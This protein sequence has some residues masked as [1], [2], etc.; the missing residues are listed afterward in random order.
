M[1]E[2]ERQQKL[3]K[4]VAFRADTA[5]AKPEIYE[6]LK[7]RGVKYAICIPANEN[8]ERDVAELLPRPVGRLSHKPIVWYKVFLYRAASWMMERRVVAKE[9]YHAGELFLRIRFIV[10]N[11]ETPSR[12]VVRFYNKRSTAEQ[13]VKEGKQAVKNAAMLPPFPVER[14]TAVAERDRIQL[15]QPVAEAGAAEGNR[16]VVVDQLAAAASEDRQPVGK[17]CPL[18]LA[19]VAESHLTRRLFAGM[20]RRILALSLSAG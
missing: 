18:L 7:S 16:N 4:E 15:G 20:L 13:W 19:V 11:L 8:L 14:G 2:I 3:S 17:A 9:V 1:P 6:A 12:A 5:Y 10:T